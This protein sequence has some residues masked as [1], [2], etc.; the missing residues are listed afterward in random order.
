MRQLL[1]GFVLFVCA[2]ATFAQK[3]S[4]VFIWAG[5]DA[6]A[7]SDFLAVLDADPDSP[8]YGRAVASVA[9][10]GPSGGPHHTELEMPAGGF[11]MANAF[12]SGRSFI[13]DLREPRRPQ[14]GRASCRERV[15]VCVDG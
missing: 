5:D 14:I 4:Y 7:G 12:G 9:V 1:C 8:Q 10:P 15:E 6:K 3:G 13:F 11:L 2:T